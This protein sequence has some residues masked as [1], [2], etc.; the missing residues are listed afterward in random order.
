MQQVTFK[1]CKMQNI[2]IIYTSVVPFQGKQGGL[3]NFDNRK[4]TYQNDTI[5]RKIDNKTPTVMPKHDALIARLEC[6]FKE[7]ET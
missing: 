1:L 7:W 3:I 2:Q 4:K 5:K 6:T